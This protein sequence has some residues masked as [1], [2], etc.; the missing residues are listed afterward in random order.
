MRSVFEAHLCTWPI[1]EAYPRLVA[2]RAQFNL[3]CAGPLRWTPLV[4]TA[5]RSLRSRFRASPAP[6]ALPKA[7]HRRLD[8]RPLHRRLIGQA[9]NRERSERPASSVCIG[10]LP[11][12]DACAPVGTH[13]PPNPT[14]NTPAPTAHS[15]TRNRERSER[16][17]SR[18]F[19]SPNPR[20]PKPIHRLIRPRRSRIAPWACTS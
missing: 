3:K 16:P 15:Q 10:Q 11:R 13:R 17:A 5:G 14:P 2:W 7:P 6:S 4:W 20:R 9:R 19:D 1:I 12:P 8:A 18:V